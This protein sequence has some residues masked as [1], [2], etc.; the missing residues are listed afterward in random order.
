MPTVIVSHVV[1]DVATLFAV[2]LFITIIGGFL[3][4][5]AFLQNRNTPALA[6]WGTGY[7]IGA[8]GAA[9]LS[10]QATAVPGA[11]AVCAANTLLCTAYRFMWCGAR[12][13]EGR[14]VSLIGLV[15][16]PAVWLGAFQ[17]AGFA[18]S[19]EERISLV[20][21]IS[22]SYA[23]LAAR[24]MVRP[25]PRADLA[26]ADIGS[27]DRTCGFSSGTHPVRARARIDSQ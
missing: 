4:L 27:G 10:G 13:F 5:F 7:L 18:Q 11:W 19:L 23:L 3:L 2:T 15:L 1:L 24:T 22:A 6:L 16:G 9:L 12:S 20:A 21:A 25:R 14:R 17:F 8:A 26:L